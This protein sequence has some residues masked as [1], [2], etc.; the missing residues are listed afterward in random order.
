MIGDY[1]FTFALATGTI[2]PGSGAV[3][4]DLAGSTLIISEPLSASTSLSA[5]AV[6]TLDGSS[7]RITV[8]ETVEN[9]V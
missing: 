9:R 4:L 2:I 1:Q 7:I 5:S 3:E 8:S 6:F